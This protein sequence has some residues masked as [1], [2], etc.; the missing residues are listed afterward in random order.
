MEL[1][2]LGLGSNLAGTLDNPKEQ[3]N[4]A[5]QTLSEHPKLNDLVCSSFYCTNPIGPQDQPDYINAVVR[6]YT[7][8][9]P[10]DLL[11]YLQT[12]E[13]GQERI[14]D[15][16][17]GPRTL[18]L[19]ILIYGKLVLNERR[20]TIPHPR[21]SERAFV[22]LPMSEIDPQLVITDCKTV[23]DLLENC[24]DQRIVKLQK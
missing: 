4:K 2:Y 1:V 7:C 10:F 8:L 24:L 9:P 23:T 18:D 5:L 19:D 21:M 17:W 6:L 15:R 20:L 14:R 16:R 22:L 12:I 11:D 3:L 13:S